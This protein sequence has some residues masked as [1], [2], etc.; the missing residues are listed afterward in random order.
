MKKVVLQVSALLMLT[1]GFS[2]CGEGST[3]NEDVKT[4]KVEKQEPL[5]I[6][7]KHEGGYIFFLDFE[8]KHGKICAPRFEGDEKEVTQSE[9]LKFAEKLNL[10]GYSDWRLPSMDELTLIANLKKQNIFGFNAEGYWTNKRTVVDDFG[11]GDLE[12]EYVTGM[13]MGSNVKSDVHYESSTDRSNDH[14]A[15]NFRVVRDF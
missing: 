8:G 9:A 4:E 3:K 10:N 14:W 12:I 13:T 11:L 2:S 15:N 7:D 6:G 1:V 5:K